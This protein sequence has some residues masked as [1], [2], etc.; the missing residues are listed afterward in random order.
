MKIKGNLLNI[1]APA[2]LVVLLG[3][4]MSGCNESNNS[5]EMASQPVAKSTSYAL[6][7]TAGSAVKTVLNHAQASEIMTTIGGTLLDQTLS[8][9]ELAMKF[10]TKN[11]VQAR[12]DLICQNGGSLAWRWS[13]MDNDGKVSPGDTAIIALRDCELLSNTYKGTLSMVFVAPIQS[14]AAALAFD[15][16][17]KLQDLNSG[18]GKWLNISGEFNTEALL[19]SNKLT[20]QVTLNDEGLNYWKPAI[21]TRYN[22]GEVLS[23]QTV[24]DSSKFYNERLYAASIFKEQNL[25]DG[26]YRFKLFGQVASSMLNDTFVMNTGKT[27]EGPLRGFPNAGLMTFKSKRLFTRL[28][29]SKILPDWGAADYI[30][31][32]QGDGRLDGYAYPDLWYNYFGQQFL[33]YDTL[34]WNVTNRS[35]DYILASGIG[36]RLL[37]LYSPDSEEGRSL[38]LKSATPKLIYQFSKPVNKDTIAGFELYYWPAGSAVAQK[39]AVTTLVHGAQIILHPAQPLAPGSYSLRYLGTT[40]TDINNQYS[41]YLV[42]TGFEVSSQIIAKAKASVSAA[43]VGRLVS[44]N[45]LANNSLAAPVSYLWSQ[46]AGPKATILNANTARASFVVPALTTASELLKFQVAI[47]DTNG[48]TQLGV[49]S[50]YAYQNEDSFELL[51]YVSDL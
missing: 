41:T 5:G 17:V 32:T 34:L 11:H 38:T 24:I 2:L 29:A 36:L 15:T 18:S 6:S 45:V 8:F 3:A 35:D 1:K 43:K 20:V 44:L 12:V 14:N 25:V 26:R 37:G 28:S 50:V 49:V 7:S 4:G 42:D 33:F 47:T 51:D 30:Y 10:A 21:N 16:Q 22:Y 48:A 39:I 19:T 9:A 46:V 40:I 23:P 31:D 13:D 27:F